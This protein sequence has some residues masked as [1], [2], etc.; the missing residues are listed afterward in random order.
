MGVTMYW[1]IVAAV[2]ILGKTMPQHGKK[3]IYY[4]TAMALLHALVSGLRY[5][6]LTG[7]LGKYR[8][9]YVDYLNHGYFSEHMLNEGVNTGF[10]W[11]SKFVSTLS[12]GDFQVFL[13]VIAIIIEVAVAVVVYKYSPLPWIS[14]L[15][16][17][18]IGFYIFGFSAL[19]QSLAMAL[20]ILAME[21]VLENR[22]FRFLLLTVIAGYVHFP[23]F[24]FLPAYWFA[25]A[26]IKPLTVVCYV[27]AALT[28]LA[29]QGPIVKFVTNI[30][31]E[32]GEMILAEEA[33]LG[34][35]FFMMVV[36]LVMGI[37]LKGFSDR[38]FEKTFNMMVVAA[39]FQM[40]SGYDN[41]FTRFADYYFQ[42]SILFLPLMV[43]S[44]ATDPRLGG[45]HSMAIFR[46]NKRSLEAIT[47]CM[48]LY[49]IWYYNR[50]CLGLNVGNSVD[51]YLNYR[52]MWYY[53]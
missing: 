24:A 29:F 16:W 28:I 34:G 5:E 43:S 39:I 22:L 45:S 9:N 32:E 40:F 18:C 15:V 10:Y 50:T 26:R 12:N 4:I 53:R 14:Y 23:A 35:R 8:W 13:M 20:V 2:V 38:R 41:I 19:K 21:A 46:F 27:I 25:K 37:C 3:R 44:P 47:L 6:Y 11:F 17:N 7:D 49:L 30:Y 51:N 1:I 36:I 31:Y 42:I 33:A 48:A 52:S